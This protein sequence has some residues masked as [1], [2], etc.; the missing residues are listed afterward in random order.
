MPAGLSD[1]LQL[2][3]VLRGA[4]QGI[5]REPFQP[6]GLWSDETIDSFVTRRFGKHVARNIV[7]GMV[8]GIYGGDMVTS[9]SCP[10]NL[11]FLDC[12]I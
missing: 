6:K 7:G 10:S 12:M 8:S 9:P 5:L 3:S 1:L 4:I 2:P 11:V